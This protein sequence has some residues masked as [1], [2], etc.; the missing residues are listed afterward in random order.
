MSLD[1]ILSLIFL[2]NILLLGCYGFIIVDFK[3]KWKDRKWRLYF[4]ICFILL[5]QAIL[6]L[7]NDF[8]FSNYSNFVIPFELLYGPF[9]LLIAKENDVTKTFKFHKLYWAPFLFFL[10][11]SIFL[12]STQSIDIYDIKYFWVSF[13]FSVALFTFYCIT[14][15]I[16]YKMYLIKRQLGDTYNFLVEQILFVLILLGLLNLSQFIDELSSFSDDIEHVFFLNHLLLLIAMWLI[17]GVLL[18]RGVWIERKEKFALKSFRKEMKKQMQTTDLPMESSVEEEVNEELL[19]LKGLL[20]GLP[21]W[22]FINPD[23]NLEG[24]SKELHAPKPLVSQVLTTVLGTN[25]SRFV[26]EKRIEYAV[27]LLMDTSPSAL[28]NLEEIAFASGFNTVRSFYRAFS[29]KYNMSPNK[30]KKVM[31]APDCLGTSEK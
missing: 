16:R 21:Q 20:L 28:S 12:Y 31:Q 6:I 11:V 10:V 25:F 3:T 8:V 13:Y 1:R 17:H 27:E 26:N 18:R 19:E 5:S 2:S 24:L 29:A 30:Y 7:L 23:L 14:K 4:G 15:V 22:F 9:F